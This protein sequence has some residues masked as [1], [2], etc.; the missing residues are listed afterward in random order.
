[1]NLLKR[2]V[3]FIVLF[4]L[5]NCRN[6]TEKNTTAETNLLQTDF[7]PATYASLLDSAVASGE[8]SEEDRELVLQFIRNH[9]TSIPEGHTLHS[10]LQ[11]ARGMEFMLNEGISVRVSKGNVT[12]DRKIYGFHLHLIARNKCET[13]ITGL[14]G[15][16]QW[17]NSEGEILKNS[18]V[19]SIRGKLPPEEMM[20]NVLL[21]TAYY[22]PTGNELNSPKL[23]AW[24]D[25]LELM[26]KSVENF[27]SSRFK[28][29]LIDIRLSN[30]LTPSQYWLKPL[31][32]RSE[33]KNA[34]VESQ[35]PARLQSWPKKNKDWIQKLTTGLGEHYLEITPILTNKGE[36]THGEYL[37]FDRIK[38][39]ERFFRL[40]VKVPA[41]RINPANK[42]GQMVHYEEVAFWNWPMELRIYQSEID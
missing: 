16:I 20:D 3:P 31:K 32:E 10:L 7:A 30:G 4:F 9:S 15:Y 21:Q 36:G 42:S 8:L 18:P 11:G 22:K 17:L 37:L 2:I 12:T 40:H 27:D 5:F 14:R 24:R 26:E 28:F 39:V 34:E 33:F 29:R 1:M 13:G 19:F 35:T 38:K 41:Q 23:N 6:G 25:T